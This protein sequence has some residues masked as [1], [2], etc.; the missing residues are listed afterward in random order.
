MSFSH[1]RKQGVLATHS[2]V[3]LNTILKRLS[4]N[5]YVTAGSVVFFRMT[6]YLA[7]N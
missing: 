6:F 3:I 5:F 2:I 4:L 7:F 1:F